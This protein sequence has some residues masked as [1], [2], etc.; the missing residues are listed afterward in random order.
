MLALT[1]TRE[2]EVDYDWPPTDCSVQLSEQESSGWG[3]A[4]L[5]GAQ[6]QNKG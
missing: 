1:K 6:R 5:N 4:L 3:Q 2:G